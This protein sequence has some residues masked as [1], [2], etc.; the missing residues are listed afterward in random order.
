ALEPAV[1]AL[2]RDGVVPG[3]DRGRRQGRQDVRLLRHRFLPGAPGAQRGS[4]VM[5]MAERALLRVRGL[6]KFYV[7]RVGCLDVGFD[8]WPGEVLG[9][10]GESGWGKT[11]ILNCLSGRIRASAGGAEYMPR[12]G[13]IADVLRLAEPARRRLL[14]TEW[15]VVHQNPRDGL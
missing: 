6:T 2:R 3:R 12:D 15:G 9:L 14:R 11:T 1:R 7:A 13:A 10:V 8:V 5:G 4:P